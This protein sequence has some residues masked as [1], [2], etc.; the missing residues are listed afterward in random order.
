SASTVPARMAPQLM[1]VPTEAMSSQ[2]GM[3]GESFMRISPWS[4]VQT[5]LVE[6][7]KALSAFAA[8]KEKSEKDKGQRKAK[9]HRG[10]PPA[11]VSEPLHCVFQHGGPFDLT[12]RFE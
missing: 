2:R 6:C 4:Q 1:R 3:E 8:A 5:E 7:A 11:K 10:E 12:F 9:E